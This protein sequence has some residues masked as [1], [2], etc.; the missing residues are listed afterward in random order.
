MTQ[1]DQEIPRLFQEMKEHFVKLGFLIP[2]GTPLINDGRPFRFSRDGESRKKN[3]WLF[4]SLMN[5]VT[6]PGQFIVA[7]VGDWSLGDD[8]H[9]FKSGGLAYDELDH[10]SI[11]K[12][13]EAM[14]RRALKEKTRVQSEACDEAARLFGQGEKKPH[15][16]LK[17]KNLSEYHGTLVHPEDNALMVPMRGANGKLYGI[18]RIYSNGTKLFLSGQRKDET[19]H[20]IPDSVDPCKETVLVLCE[21]FA[22]GASIHEC[23]KRTVIVCFDAGNLVKVAKALSIE[24]P[25]ATFVIAGDDDRLNEINTGAEAAEKARI[26]SGGTVCLPSFP[27]GEVE[28]TDFND[29]HHL[30]GKQAVFDQIEKAVSSHRP[31]YIRCLGVDKDGHFLTSSEN[32]R[33][34]CIK[35]MDTMNLLRLMGIGYWERRYPGKKGNVDWMLAASDLMSKCRIA[36]QYG[37]S[38]TRGRGVWLDEKRLVVNLGNKLWIQGREV[39]LHGIKTQF[40][41]VA[42]EIMDPISENPLSVEELAPWREAVGLL[43]VRDSWARMFLLGWPVQAL[44]GGAAKWRTHMHLTGESG[45]GKSTILDDLI[46]PLAQ[47]MG[48]KFGGGVTEAGIRNR[49]GSGAIVGVVDEM[50]SRNRDAKA[51]IELVLDYIRQSSSGGRVVKGAANGGF[52]EYSAYSSFVLASVEDIIQKDTDATRFIQVHFLKRSEDPDQWKKLCHK[53]DGLKSGNFG[54]RFLARCINSFKSFQ[55]S[56]EIF[57]RL[58][59]RE[60][61]ERIAQLYSGVLA[62]YQVVISDE[63]VTEEEASALISQIN[64]ADEKS[65]SQEKDWTEMLDDLMSARATSQGLDGRLETV[66]VSELVYAEKVAMGSANQRLERFGMKYIRKHSGKEGLF[67]ARRHTELSRL[68]KDNDLTQSLS[69]ILLRAP[70]AERDTQSVAHRNLRGVFLPDA[71]LW[72]IK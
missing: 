52:I 66:S 30:C 44:L 55:A 21:G 46:W 4:S 69:T 64:R 59:A 57:F 42:D 16:Y 27:F 68:L 63:V 31:Q 29:L 20:A 50:E 26:I 70:E 13:I 47:P 3:A 9:T 41:Y 18:Q 36:G 23:T 6:K 22:T 33:V 51:R 37:S 45:A 15:P 32:K 10:D 19:F 8:T 28:A 60:Q 67:V 62:G 58:I 5:H 35:S 49:I 61:G 56:Q 72:S 34:L 54:D 24:N 12:Q 2:D 39:D 7:T 71:L 40:N 14:K 11:K 48:L 38:Q 65:T 25:E 43:R 1:L 17:L 53:I